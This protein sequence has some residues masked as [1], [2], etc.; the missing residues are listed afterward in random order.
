MTKSMLVIAGALLAAHAQAGALEESGV[1]G[2]LVV[3]IGCDDPALIAEL[4][5]SEK[6]LVQ[7]LDTDAAKV[8]RVREAVRRGGRY[9]RVSAAT[10]SG[11][12]LPYAENL[13]NLVLVR[14]RDCAV[15]AGEVR[16][17]LAPR[18]VVIGPGG[19]RSVPRPSVRIADGSVKFTKPFPEDMDEWSHYLRDPDNNAVSRDLRVSTPTRLQWVSGP[20]WS[21]NH[22]HMSS[23]SAVVTSAGR[24]F[25][26]IDEGSRASIQYPPDWKVVARDAFNGKLLW[27][28][29]IPKWHSHLWPAKAG[30]A[31]LPRRLVAVGGKVYV[32]LGL[33]APVSM[34][35]AATGETIRTFDETEHTEEIIVSGDRLFVTAHATAPPDARWKLETVRCWTETGR[36]NSSRP[37]MWERADPKKIIAVDVGSGRVVWAKETTVAPITLAADERR[38]IYHDGT[39]VVCLDRRSGEEMWTSELKLDVKALVK[40]A[41]NLVIYGKVVLFSPGPGEVM[42]ISI[43]D[44]KTLWIDSHG[45]SGHQSTYDLLVADGLVWSTSRGRVRGKGKDLAEARKLAKRPAW[46]YI[47]RDPVTGEVKKTFPP[48]RSDWFHHRCHRGRGTNR[49][50]IMS[51]TGIEYI[52]LE[53]GKW[54]PN[55]WVRGACLYGIM[56]A[57][58]MTYAPPHPCACYIESKL[59]GFNA[60]LGADA[61]EAPRAAARARA[62]I[63]EVLRARGRRADVHRAAA[64]RLADVPLRQHAERREQVRGRREA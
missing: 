29:A 19:A 39:V 63:R 28:R 53:T 61:A 32:T 59:S 57:N 43:D 31:Q 42:S 45:R 21:R 55:P 8:E 1:T 30:P 22:D 17:V 41:P 7:A 40:A 12:A 47:G 49:Y 64:L 37:W 52:N 58:G 10:F 38:V 20:K 50:L 56:P 11:R 4:G 51:R 24:I 13:V 6:F 27:K 48:G 15:P 46:T 34:L 16:R 25:S 26:I 18:G 2:G 9:G 36:S 44:G 23:V 3:V 35:D 62:G 60:L 33:H 54:T 14:D 5:R